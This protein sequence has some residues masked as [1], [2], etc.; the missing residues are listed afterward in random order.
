MAERDLLQEGFFLDVRAPCE[1]R[2]GH[3]PNSVNIPI[4]NDLERD[5]V[6]KAYRKH[7][8]ERAVNLGHE[9]CS[10]ARKSKLLQD[11][12]TE[13]N[14][15]NSLNLLCLRGGL[16][17]QIAS[18]WLQEIGETIRPVEGG[19]KVLRQTCLSLLEKPDKKFWIIGGKTGSGKTEIIKNLSNS[20]DL[21]GRAS[22]RG[23]AFGG[24]LK[25]Q[26]S[27]STFENFLAVDYLNLDRNSLVLEDEG[28]SIGSVSIPPSWF[29]LMRASPIAL[30]K[31]DLEDRVARIKAEYVDDALLEYGDD[32]VAVQ[33]LHERYQESARKIAKRLGATN[34][35]SLRVLMEEAF[36][37]KREHNDWIEHLLSNYY[38]P[39]YEY[40]LKRKSERIVFSGDSVAVKDFL[41]SKP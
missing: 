4:L 3:L 16:R 15:K 7:G 28:R 39:M 31:L 37:E 9:L 18:K 26:P 14:K 11:W 21:E 38:D 2:R 25:E 6:G 40:Q 1:F 36:L 20:I 12:V 5:L 34:L 30:V 33:Q 27:L 32:S 24:R 13:I 29:D 10:G 17:S 23:S 19:Y 41:D 22:H 35:A 8:K